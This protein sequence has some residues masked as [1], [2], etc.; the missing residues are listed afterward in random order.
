[1][2][3]FRILVSRFAGLFGNDRFEREL[4]EEMQSH[5]A[6]LLEE[7]LRRGMLPDEA[8]RAALR[9]F[10][11]VEQAKE[12]YRDQRGL[13]FLETL[14][15]DARYGLRMLAKNPGFTA[16]AV[17]TL[18]L[19][20]GANTTI[21]SVV[22]AALIHP[23]PFRD[24]DRL[25]T[26][27][28]T[29]PEIGYS[30]PLRTCGRDYAG[31]RD[32]NHVFDQMGAYS[33]WAPSLTGAGEPARLLGAQITAGLFPMLGVTPAWGRNF[34][35]EENQTGHEHE[36]LLC[37]K[38]WRRRFHADGAILD[39]SITLDNE[40]YTVVGIMP[41]GFGFPNESDFWTPLPLTNDCSNATLL[42]IARLKS[43]VTIETAQADVS[44]IAR[45]LDRDHGVSDNFHVTL[46][47]LTRV[48]GGDLRPVLLVL[49]AAVGF[50]LLIACANVAN[51]LLTRAAGRQREIAIRSAL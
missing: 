4:N 12:A 46:V 31:W 44:V 8:R 47:P 7:N 19:G 15:R 43:G 11:G 29:F 21:F 33:E 5:L 20:I 13:P 49:L 34:L 40:L 32:Q 18:A 17:L 27:W 42:A 1:M 50:V 48:M 36:A 26:Q 16:V 6:M 9:S 39:K 35:P 25:V 51:L 23:L 28:G 24:A 30:G 45:R 2:S 22:N 37:D 41:A 10:G 38:L 14:I 3:W